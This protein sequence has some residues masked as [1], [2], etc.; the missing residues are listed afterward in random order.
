MTMLKKAAYFLGLPLILLAAWVAYTSVTTNFFVPE[1]AVLAER[2]FSI[3]FS[4]RF[5][6][7]VLPSLG[8]LLAGLA[9]SIVIGVGVG[10]VIGY[11]RWIRWLF[12]PLFEFIRAVPSTILIPVLLLLIGINDSM[13]VTLIVFSCV[14]PILLNT[15]AGVTGIDEVLSNTSR[16]LG[17]RGFAR[18]RHLVLPAAS[19]QIMAGIRQS[20]AVALILMVVSEMFAS[21]DGIGHWT[22]NFQNRVAIPEMWSGILLLGLIGVVLSVVFQWIQKRTLSWYEGLKENEND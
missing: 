12:E 5:A 13:K 3:W 1:P 19:P 17:L 9:L 6:S 11:V 8:R 21:T 7:D 22:I 4:E 14:W 10:V 18:M 16:V 2:F 20:L 15:V